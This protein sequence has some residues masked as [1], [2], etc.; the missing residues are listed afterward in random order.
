MKI[1]L[2]VLFAVLM[3]CGG[4]VSAQSSDTISVTSMQCGMCESRIEK[5][6][7]A[8]GLVTE[9]EADVEHEIVVVHYD[10]K[11]VSKKQLAELISK[12]GYDTDMVA[13]D[14]KA[15]DA[16]HGCCKPGAHKKPA[17]QK[18]VQKASPAR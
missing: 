11:K 12:T 14:A 18:R 15:Q 17:P 9:V 10:G 3:I 16:L 8:S 4:S 5:A 6:L 7:K 13:A 2:L 1:N